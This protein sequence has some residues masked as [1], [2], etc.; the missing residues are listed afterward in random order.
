M[1]LDQKK[2]MDTIARILNDDGLHTR[3]GTHWTTGTVRY[4][5]LH[6]AYKG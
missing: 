4:I 6:S 2:G 3:S 1:Y 5:L